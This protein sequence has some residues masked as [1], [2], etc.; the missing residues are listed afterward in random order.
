MPDPH[1]H[2]IEQFSRWEAVGRGTL[3]PQGEP[4]LL[5]PP[6]VPFKGYVRP[7]PTNRDDGRRPTLFSRA[8]DALR[9]TPPPVSTE[10][11]EDEVPPSVEGFRLGALTGVSVSLPPGY[12]PNP[13]ASRAMLIQLQECREPLALEL[14]GTQK[15]VRLQFV[16]SPSDAEFLVA[17]L[18]SLFPEAIFQGNSDSLQSA[19]ERA[20]PETLSLIECGLGREF[21]LPLGASATDPYVGLVGA[22][23]DLRSGEFGAFQIL[24]QPAAGLWSESLLQS[25]L[26]PDGKPYPWVD[27][28]LVDGATQKVGRPMWA[29]C[30]RL[31]G[32]GDSPESSWATI[33]RLAAP[34]NLLADPMGNFLVPLVR[35]DEGGQDGLFNDFIRRESRRPGM[36]LNQDELLGLVHIPGA[37]VVSPKFSRQLA[38][39][40]AAPLSV[41]AAS[42][43]YLGENEHH[44]ETCSTYLGSE[45]RIRHVH[46]VGSSGTGKS[47][48]L[49][50][51]ILDDIRAGQ[52]VA[53]LDPHGDLIDSILGQLPEERI[54]DVVLLD[55]S[56]EEASV[57]FN[58]LSANSDAERIMLAS[59]L[60]SVFERLSTSWGDQMNVVLRNAILAFLESTKG[61]TLPDLRRFLIDQQ[62]RK[63]FLQTVTDPDIRYYWET[64]FPQFGT[65]QS[66][67]AVVTRLETF[68]APKPVRYS[69]SQEASTLDFA[70]IMDNGKTLLC[71]L[72]QGLIGK[73]NAYL[74]GSL[75]VSKLQQTAMSRQR[76]EASTRRDFWCYI[77]EFQNFLTESMAEI[78]TEARKYRLGLVLAHQNLAQIERCREVGS[79]V[80]ANT[81][82]RIV[83]RV[84]D[85][86]AKALAPGFS[87]FEGADLQSLERGEAIVRVER[88]DHDFNITV[89]WREP[90][91]E[92]E[93][94]DRRK[95]TVALSREKYAVRRSEVEA[96]LSQKLGHDDD[97]PESERKQAPAETETAEGT[98]ADGNASPLPGKGG[99]EHR[100][101]QHEIE[102]M[103]RDAGF[104]SRIE[105]DIGGGRS[106]DVAVE[107]EEH[108]IACEITITTP[109]HHE[110]GNIE[111]C[112]GADFDP[113]VLICP[114]PRKRKW[115]R[116]AIDGRFGNDAGRIHCIPI[117]EFEG[118]LKKLQPREDKQMTGQEKKPENPLG[119]KVKRNYAPT[120]DATALGALAKIAKILRG[121]R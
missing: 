88:S 28:Q 106:V 109:T 25:V 89:P 54:E 13:D 79:A 65:R 105:C 27:R 103:A 83:F 120:N 116:K 31:V 121:D 51:L 62:F 6:F 112:L 101:L 50:N 49:K 56:D 32:A 93:Q 5:E 60:V 59:D 55:P 84:G 15:V 47:T 104:R 11:G 40:K 75:V 26:A 92:A 117:S 78:L 81:N 41:R 20:N 33:S 12:S 64:V 80:L 111:K 107:N 30:L 18:R 94:S 74:F 44:G 39:T 86:D 102:R 77:D 113:V 24:F 7:K 16:T 97:P 3:P 114:S 98:S 95:R 52:G 29:T 119:F 46:V 36:L 8:L 22:L 17:M 91:A 19:I 58:I 71:R 110:L 115:L 14:F 67:G 21:H 73:E 63:D 57:A 85:R 118:L 2:F 37:E 96:Q 38:R 108:S 43:L 100:T 9:T 45:Q 90:P 82:I 42:G 99:E 61:G 34:L 48:L 68:L 53:V 1:D 4:V 69:V 23:S 10:N 72:S 76:L 87:G 66:V 70:D 35:E